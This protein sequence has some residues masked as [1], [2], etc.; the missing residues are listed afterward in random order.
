MLAFLK[1]LF[2]PKIAN[3]A[4]AWQQAGN[5][6]ASGYWL[7]AAPVHLVLQRDTFSLAEPVPLVLNQE[8]SDALTAALNK[9]FAEEGLDNKAMFFWRENK[10]FLRLDSNPNIQTHAP[11]ASLNKAV[12][13]YLP[14]GEGAMQWASF[15][16]EIQMLLFEHSVNVLREAKRLP[17]V[18]SVWCYGGGQIETKNHAN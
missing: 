6:A 14:T 15:T 7:Y 13:A 5:Q 17:V 11:Q 8:E 3:A 18:N 16:N 9:H 2:Q 12:G 4:I 1:N 10:W